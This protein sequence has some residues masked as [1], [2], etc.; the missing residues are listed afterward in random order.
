M[1]GPTPPVTPHGVRDGD[2]TSLAGLAQRRSGSVLDYARHACGERSAMD[3]TAESFARF[4]AAVVAADDLRNLAPD[5]LLLSCTRNAAAAFVPVA[6]GGGPACHATPHL[7]VGRFEATNTAADA[8]RLA[9]HLETCP[10]CTERAAAFDRAERA[11]R[12]PHPPAPGG[13]V[14]ARVIAALEASASAGRVL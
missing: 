4:R 12:A 13:V 9:R 14:V 6:G 5:A 11:F 2:P 8:G 7:I 10:T 1:H 3:A